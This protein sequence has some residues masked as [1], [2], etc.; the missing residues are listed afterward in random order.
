M[1]I[2]DFPANP[3]HLKVRCPRA[4]LASWAVPNGGR[5]CADRP[6]F[7]VRRGRLFHPVRQWRHSL[8]GGESRFHSAGTFVSTGCS[9]GTIAQMRG[10]FRRNNGN[11]STTCSTRCC[12]FGCFEYTEFGRPSACGRTSFRRGRCG[13]TLKALRKICLC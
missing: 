6:A 13:C 4:A 3:Y 2:D 10:P 9:V 1:R 7:G 5:A 12:T 8:R 11:A